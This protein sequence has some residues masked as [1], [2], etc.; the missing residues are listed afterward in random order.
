MSSFE[1]TELNKA[2]VR[3]P[4]AAHSPRLAW[5]R[6]PAK[7]CDLLPLMKLE[8]IG[9]TIVE[10]LQAT[11]PRRW[12]AGRAG[13]RW[14]R[15]GTRR[16]GQRIGRCTG[17]SLGLDGSRPPG[18]PGSPSKSRRSVGS[19]PVGSDRP[20]SSWRGTIGPSSAS[21]GSRPPGAWI[22][23]GEPGWSPRSVGRAGLRSSRFSTRRADSTR[24]DMT[25][26]SRLGHSA[27]RGHPACPKPR[28]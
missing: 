14:C 20:N 15:S 6:T 19:W 8:R 16:A 25:G 2:R 9:W 24:S 10:T 21:P 18:S 17:R 13:L 1:S 12:S 26:E 3:P 22:P 11:C 23:W 5:R 4:S 27:C 28:R 7:V